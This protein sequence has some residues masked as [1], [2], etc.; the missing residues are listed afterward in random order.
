MFE[1]I[2][3]QLSDQPRSFTRTNQRRS[4]SPIRVFSG[5]EDARRLW[6]RQRHY[7]EGEMH[8]NEGAQEDIWRTGSCTFPPPHLRYP[9]ACKGETTPN[10]CPALLKWKLRG[11]SAA[12][13]QSAL[14]WLKHATSAYQY[15]GQQPE[16]RD[17]KGVKTKNME[18]PNR[19]PDSTT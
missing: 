14:D 11:N 3:N 16:D 12:R 1:R 19:G 6:M 13:R 5:F 17:R 18:E 8:K 7:A 10:G 15:G 4:G 9:R 2:R